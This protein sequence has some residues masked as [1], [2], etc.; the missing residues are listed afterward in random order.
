M[1]VTELI[2]HLSQFPPDAVVLADCYRQP[3]DITRMY[4]VQTARMATG[5]L[6]KTNGNKFVVL[7]DG[8]API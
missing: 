3:G 1:T 4:T 5:A 8:V 2:N 7:G 6:A